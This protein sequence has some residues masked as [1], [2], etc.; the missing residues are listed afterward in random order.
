MHFLSE[1]LEQYIAKHS[2]PEPPLLQELSRETH[3]KVIQA[4]MITGHFQGRVLSMLSHIIAPKRIL[5]Q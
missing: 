3:L 5:V 2:E 1:D 4:R